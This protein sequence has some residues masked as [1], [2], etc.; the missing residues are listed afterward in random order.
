MRFNKEQIK[1]ILG[2]VGTRD[3]TIIE[4]ETN[5]EGAD[6]YVYALDITNH[7]EK[8]ESLIE[9]DDANDVTD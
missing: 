3:R 4:F 8:L 9:D 1:E 6:T 5:G 7:V 2:Y